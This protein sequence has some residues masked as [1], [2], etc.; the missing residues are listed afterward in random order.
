MT[1][2]EELNR[3]RWSSRHGRRYKLDWMAIQAED[4]IAALSPY[5]NIQE[6]MPSAFYVLVASVLL[7]RVKESN[8]DAAHLAVWKLLLRYPDSMSLAYIKPIDIQHLFADIRFQ[9][10]RATLIVDMAKQWTMGIR[11]WPITEF[12][13]GPMP[14]DG[15][16]DF[17]MDSYRLFV[18]REV[19][20]PFKYKPFIQFVKW[21]K[22]EAKE[23]RPT[24][25][26]YEVD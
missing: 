1:I 8:I 6:M 3:Y 4:P 12:M 20:L 15:V 19:N 17:I 7:D 10:K 14:M 26:K 11:P 23:G 2:K 16:S 24:H 22:D 21:A 25:R 13:G 18:L 9:R 5:Q